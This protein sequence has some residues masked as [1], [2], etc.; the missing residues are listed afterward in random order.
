MVQFVHGMEGR[1]PSSFAGTQAGG[2]SQ[3]A[4][5]LVGHRERWVSWNMG[6]GE[7]QAA[8]IRWQPWIVWY[9]ML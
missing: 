9:L 4:A 2:V 3:V 6:K 7:C 8:G 1:E 5:G